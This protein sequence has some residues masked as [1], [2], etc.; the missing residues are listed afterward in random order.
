MRGRQFQLCKD[1]VAL[2]LYDGK[3]DL[4]HIPCGAVVTLLCENADKDGTVGVFWEDKIFWM[5]FV[6]VE[7]RGEFLAD[8][9]TA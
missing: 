7:K 4:V 5:F 1:T 8:R 9:T 2:L 3:H 6:D